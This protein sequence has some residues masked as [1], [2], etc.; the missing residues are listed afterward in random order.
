MHPVILTIPDASVHPIVPITACAR[1]LSRLRM[2]VCFDSWHCGRLILVRSALNLRALC[3]QVLAPAASALPD[4]AAALDAVLQLELATNPAW[5]TSLVAADAVAGCLLFRGPSGLARASL[6]VVNS[7]AFEGQAG[8]DWDA[9]LRLL[10]T[11]RDALLGPRSRMPPEVRAKWEA[12]L[13]ASDDAVR[14]ARLL[15]RLGFAVPPV[16]IAQ[17]DTAGLVALLRECLKASAALAHGAGAGAIPVDEVDA[18]E[19][20]TFA[21]LWRDARDL[22]AFGFGRALSMTRVLEEFVRAALFASSWAVAERCAAHHS[23]RLHGVDCFVEQR[24]H[25][26]KCYPCASRRNDHRHWLFAICRGFACMLQAR[27][28]DV[29][30]TQWLQV[31]R[32]HAASVNRQAHS[33]AADQQRRGRLLCAGRVRVVD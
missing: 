17:S 30:T 10:G 33:R 27:Q 7:F 23:L 25:R 5:A 32:G 9:L 29:L 22:H 31:P 24:S 3:L 18:D 13:N 8:P 2:H 11:V 12:K 26:G 19:G 1:V 15:S 14:A 4:L 28:S 6:K 16:V 20:D 21:R